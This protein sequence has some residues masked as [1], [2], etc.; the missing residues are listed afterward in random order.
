M[1]INPMTNDTKPGAPEATAVSARES[2]DDYQ[3]VILQINRGLR[4]INCKDN[5]QWVVQRK[6]GATWRGISFLRYR[7]TLISSL[8]RLRANLTIEHFKILNDL[9]EVHP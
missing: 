2:H 7:V 5:L 4:V 3:D 9:P 6:V 8:A 1:T